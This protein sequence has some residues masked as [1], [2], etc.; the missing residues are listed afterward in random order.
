[1]IRQLVD[2]CLSLARHGEETDERIRALGEE[3]RELGEDIHALINTIDKLLR[4]N[5]S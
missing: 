4:R 1:M 3:V 5:G 2:V